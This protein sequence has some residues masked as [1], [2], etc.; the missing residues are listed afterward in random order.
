MTYLNRVFNKTFASNKKFKNI[1]QLINRNIENLIINLSI[2]PSL[3][4]VK[5]ENI[6][7]GTIGMFGLFNLLYLNCYILGLSAR[8]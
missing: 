2:Q 8:S 4:T 3:N 7:V 5:K 6:N 1:C